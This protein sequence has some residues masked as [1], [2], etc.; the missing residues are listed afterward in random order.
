MTRRLV[1]GLIAAS[2]ALGLAAPALGAP[3]AFPSFR[4]EGY[5]KPSP[6]NLDVAS[7]IL[8][9]ASGGVVLAERNADEQRAPA[10]IT[11]ILTVLVALEEADP[12][13]MVTISSRAAATG[14]REI[15][16]VAGEQVPLDSLLKAAMIHSANDA[17]T[18]I[19]EHVGGSVDGFAAMMNAK[20][21]ELGMTR[22]HFVNPHGLDANGHVTTAR[23]MLTLAVAAMQNPAF[24][25]IAR[26]RMMV[27]PNA[28]DGTRRIGS[29]T[30]LMLEDYDGTNGI[31]TGFTNRALLTFVASASR[32]GR[33]LYAVVLGTEERRSHF[34]AASALFNYGFDKLQMYGVLAGLAYEPTHLTMRPDPIELTASVE[35]QVH[36]AGEGLLAEAPTKPEELPDLPPPPTVTT[37]R[38]P[39]GATGPVQALVYWLDRLFGS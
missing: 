9:D 14:E 33:E 16:L 29:S 22:S 6:P 12:N 39:D 19:A 23:D 37:N 20:A 26:A 7:W 25:D 32:N 36:M 27:F 8:Y 10:S 4:Q 11:K 24:R 5:G 2:L 1:T 31:K 17:A 35:A 3:L 21:A 13:S 34:T 28:P 38:V 30:N 15:E 18:A